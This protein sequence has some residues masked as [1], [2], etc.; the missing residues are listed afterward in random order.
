MSEPTKLKAPA[1][2]DASDLSATSAEGQRFAPRLHARSEVLRARIH[3]ALLHADAEQYARIAGEVRDA[4]ED[5]VAD[6]LVDVNL[7]DITR[8]VQELRDIEA[9]LQRVGAHSYGLCIVCRQRIARERLEAYPTAK[10][11][12]QCQVRYERDRAAPPS[13]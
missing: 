5:A 11:C 6:L 7:A 8:E 3:E 1:P 9:A 12:L 2:D 4:E 13:L 10:R